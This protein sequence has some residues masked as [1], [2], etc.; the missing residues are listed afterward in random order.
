MAWWDEGGLICSLSM[1]LLQRLLCTWCLASLSRRSLCEKF[2]EKSLPEGKVRDSVCLHSHSSLNLIIWSLHFSNPCVLLQDVG[3]IK[4]SYYKIQTHIGYM[5]KIHC[6]HQWAI[7][8]WYRVNGVNAGS[9]CVPGGHLDWWFFYFWSFSAPLDFN[10][11]GIE[12][13]NHPFG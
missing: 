1:I 2:C 12:F 3:H 4:Y 13:P 11:L 8:H 7:V 5:L 10:K 9:G 6:Y